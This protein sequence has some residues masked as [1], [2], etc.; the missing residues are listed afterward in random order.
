MAEGH[1][2]DE[3]DYFNHVYES[4]VDEIKDNKRTVPKNDEKSINNWVKIYGKEIAI[5]ISEFLND[6]LWN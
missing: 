5:V 3:F 6:E 2:S 4:V 1:F